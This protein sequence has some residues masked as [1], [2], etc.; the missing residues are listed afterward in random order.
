MTP[1]KIAATAAALADIGARA[2]RDG[3]TLM[4][5]ANRLFDPKGTSKATATL[6]RYSGEHQ[7]AYSEEV[8]AIVD[9]ID[10]GVPVEIRR[11]R[12]SA[13][14]RHES[15]AERF[16]L[17]KTLTRILDEAGVEQAEQMRALSG[18]RITL[19]TLHRVVDAA[20]KVSVAA[21][22]IWNPK[23]AAKANRG[24]VVPLRLVE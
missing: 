13:K 16:T 12:E 14:S 3:A 15:E 21:P 8:A 1:D 10:A 18:R 2:A 5:T 7:Q 4:R 19:E 11:R 6:R 22:T 20:H 9:G 24:N 17:R 23:P